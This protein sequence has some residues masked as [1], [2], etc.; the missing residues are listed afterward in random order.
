MENGSLVASD[1]LSSTVYVDISNLRIR[2]WNIENTR[3]MDHSNSG[4]VKSPI[5]LANLRWDGVLW[6]PRDVNVP[7]LLKARRY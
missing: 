7:S 3:A 6:A 1:I 5:P 4:N 2:N